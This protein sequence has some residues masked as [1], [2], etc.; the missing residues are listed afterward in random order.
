MQEVILDLSVKPDA[1]DIPKVHMKQG[2]S[3]RYFRAVIQDRGAD[4]AIP[5]G[6]VITLWFAGTGGQGNYAAVDETSAFSVSGSE[7]TVRISPMMTAVKGGGVMC[8][9]LTDAAGEQLGT[10]DI[11]YVVE[12]LPG[13]DGADA[14]DTY[15]AYRDLLAQAVAA[16]ERVTDIAHGGT[17]ASSVAGAQNALRVTQYYMFAQIDPDTGNKSVDP[18]TEYPLR[19]GIFRVTTSATKMGIPSNY[20]C[21]MIF[22]GGSY[23]AH[24]YVGL[25]GFWYS[26]TGSLKVPEEWHELVTT[27]TIDALLG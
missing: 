2:D 22:N 7:V 12:P 26:Y 13:M 16:A 20:G 17:G 18:I 1:D 11:C 9:V 27:D 4:Y 24:L 21:L 23:Y 3:N 6:T 10:W 19:P 8:L 15:E 25:N 14:Q 5:T